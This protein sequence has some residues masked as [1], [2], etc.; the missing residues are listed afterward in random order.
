MKK[1]K[2]LIALA[3]VATMVISPMTTLAA[4][5]G[6]T[7]PSTGD[8][9]IENDNSVAPNY[10]AVVLPTIT[11]GTYDFKIDRDHLLA[12]FDYV[13][14]YDD[15]SYIYFNAQA[16]PATAINKAGTGNSLY[17]RKTVVTDETAKAAFLALFTE[18]TL[19]GKVAADDGYYVWVPTNAD[20]TLGE[21]EPITDDNIANI[22]K[23]DA[24]ASAAVLR[25]DHDSG[26][27]IWDG[28]IY[29][30]TYNKLSDAEAVKYITVTAGA[31]TAVDA[32]LYKAAS[33]DAL[34]L[35]AAVSKAEVADITY[36]AATT[37]YINESDA[38][39]VVNKSTTPVVVTVQVNM[40]EDT[41]LSYVGAD[42]IATSTDASLYFAIKDGNGNTVAVEDHSATAY[43]VLAGA[44][45]GT[46]LY[47]GTTTDDK[48]DSHNYYRYENPNPTYADHSFTI[49]ADVNKDEAADAA[50]DAY[51]E[52]LRAD[53]A[54]DKKPEIEV[55]YSWK[56]VEATENANEYVD[57]DGEDTYTTNGTNGW[58]E[59][60][61]AHEH[62]YDD[63]EDLAC[64]GCA[65]ARVSQITTPLTFSASTN[66]ELSYISIGAGATVSSVTVYDANEYAS[67]GSEATPVSIT[68]EVSS[69]TV[70]AK[71]NA[72]INNTDLSAAFTNPGTYLI[73]IVASSGTFTVIY[74]VAP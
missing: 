10:T 65:E 71:G 17:L 52:A 12:D 59:A 37:Q 67:S 69:F 24:V 33:T 68:L 56:V 3:C 42:E 50:W 51:V 57:L 53:G 61:S 5:S 7:T 8:S 30:D 62:T 41:Y 39:T 35:K 43:Y 66:G 48:T 44:V 38:A 1:F 26:A 60:G 31:V 72:S 9:V 54:T 23:W 70:S 25:E 74:T 2:K 40:K 14:D 27:F 47:Q 22:V 34:V 4:T 29:Y 32:D 16:T 19:T 49:V 45:N 11:D 58:A 13:N 55:V 18:E 20:P 73:E 21:F 36:T 46:T 28:K 6:E 15:D 63:Y 64:N